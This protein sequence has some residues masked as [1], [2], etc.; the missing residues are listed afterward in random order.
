MAASMLLTGTPDIADTLLSG[1]HSQHLRN[2]TYASYLGLPVDW[3]EIERKEKEETNEPQPLI[4]LPKE[5]IE[6]LTSAKAS[7]LMARN[8]RGTPP[9]FIV[10]AEF[11]PYR[12]DGVLYGQRLYGARVPLKQV[13]YRSFHGFL[14]VGFEGPMR[15][16]EGA[17]A[18]GDVINFLKAV[19]AKD[20]IDDES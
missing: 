13:N 4:D 11:D 16:E 19:T 17:M 6:A 5:V 15:T 20:K 8:I 2:T 18:F 10:T 7:P 12:D 1:N 3:S 9:T 14:N